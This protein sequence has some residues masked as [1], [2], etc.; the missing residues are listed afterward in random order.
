MP[1][2][3]IEMRVAKGKQ[4][5][6]AATLE[7]ATNISDVEVI[8]CFASGVLASKKYREYAEVQPKARTALI[9]LMIV[10]T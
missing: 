9:R 8:N 3:Q 1:K 5:R 10:K 6:V 2:D 7:R 4:T